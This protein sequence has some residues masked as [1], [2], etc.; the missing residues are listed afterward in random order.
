M[1]RLMS[2]TVAAKKTQLQSAKQGV[3]RLLVQL[4]QWPSYRD[5]GA[6]DSRIQSIRVWLAQRSMGFKFVYMVVLYDRSTSWFEIEMT[7]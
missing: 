2:S 1:K 6:I 5:A 3:G 7:S 4:Q